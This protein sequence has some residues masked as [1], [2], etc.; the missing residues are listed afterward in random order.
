MKKKVLYLDDN[1]KI[2]RDGDV[3]L[4]NTISTRIEIVTEPVGGVNFRVQAKKDV[5]QLSK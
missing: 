2:T 4:F 3:E 5:V 1:D